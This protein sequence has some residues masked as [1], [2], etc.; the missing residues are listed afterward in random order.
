MKSIALKSIL[1]GTLVLALLLCILPT[2]PKAEEVG[3]GEG[4]DT[5]DTLKVTGI[6]HTHTC[7]QLWTPFGWVTI[8]CSDTTSYDCEEPGTGCPIQPSPSP[9]PLT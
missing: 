3:G 6:H 9:R 5:S 4:G 7:H 8:W 1:P 2:S